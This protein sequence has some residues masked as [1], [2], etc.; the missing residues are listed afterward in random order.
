MPNQLSLLKSKRFL[1]IF[2]TQFFGAFNDNA[3]KNAFLIWFSYGMAQQ[4]GLDASF[5]VTLAAGLFILPFFLFS[6]TA[7]QLADKYN[8][9]LLARY[10]K[11]LEIVLMLLAA[12]CFYLESV[13]GLLAVLFFMGV[14]S[15]FFGPIKYS[16][17]PEH[18]KEKEL[19]AG[20]G[21]IEAGTFLSILLGTIFGGLV[22]SLEGGAFWLS[23]FVVVFA[24]IGWLAS[25]AIPASSLS[26]S[27][28]KIDYNL[29][30][31]TLAILKLAHK[32]PSLWLAILGISWFWHIGAS[33]LTQLPIFTKDTIKADENTLTLFLALFSLGIGLG[34]MLC[35]KL[36]KG[37]ISTKLLPGSCLAMSLSIGFF[38]VF[39]FL[40]ES[41]SLANGRQ[42]ASL[43]LVEFLQLGVYTW[44]I[45][46]SLFFLAVCG[47]IYIVPLYALMQHLPEKH[48][49]SRVIA[50]N[51]IMNA[52]FMVVSSLSALLLFSFGL[53]IV[54]LFLV[55]GVLN[56]VVFVI[57]KKI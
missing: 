32:Q 56:L 22:V 3:F 37:Q 17:L 52:L 51:N 11:L 53:G 49:T 29:A 15:S 27:G 44:G 7:G 2:I 20:N 45:V 8:K 54:Q 42:E 9:A 39:S 41:E 10:L 33:F 16:L 35:N 34:S 14:Q 30:R 19:I 18:L 57:M 1:P 43:G 12:A 31:E 50:A 46:L 28:L 47:G 25:Q 40:Y 5:M 24:I 36:L 55:I 4:A 26:N 48:Y 23:C 21:L 13:N 6:A 38:V